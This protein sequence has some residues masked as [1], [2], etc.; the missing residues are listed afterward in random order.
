MK[1][2]GL[3]RRKERSIFKKKRKLTTSLSKFPSLLVQAI[4]RDGLQDFPGGP[5]VKTPHL[6]LQRAPVQSLIG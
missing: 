1:C 3:W 6:I 4:N 2:R 5:V